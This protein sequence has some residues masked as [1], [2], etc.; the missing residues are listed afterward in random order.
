MIQKQATAIFA[1]EPSPVDDYKAQSSKLDGESE[2][3]TGT[4][5]TQDRVLLLQLQYTL[6]QQ[7][8][9]GVV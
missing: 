6:R 2:F 5:K 3:R 7:Q 1:S 8:K 4:R 9:G